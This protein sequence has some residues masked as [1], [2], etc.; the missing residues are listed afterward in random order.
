MP[1]SRAYPACK[2][3]SS[4]TA[5]AGPV[6]KQSSGN[7]MCLTGKEELTC[8]LVGPLWEGTFTKKIKG[9]FFPDIQLVPYK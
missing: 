5:V 3:R 9:K 7:L 2:H 8:E 6:T 1:R 4:E